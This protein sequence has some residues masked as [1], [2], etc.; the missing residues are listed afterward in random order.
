MMPGK[1][2]NPMPKVKIGSAYFE[3]CFTGLKFSLP[4][5]INLLT[6]VQSLLR[7]EVILSAGHFIR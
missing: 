4:F 2:L 5:H 3:G 7:V 1:I 6:F